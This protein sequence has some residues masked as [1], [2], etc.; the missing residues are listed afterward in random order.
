MTLLSSEVCF[1]YPRGH[2]L[3]K[4]F[5]A[6]PDG[7]PGFGLVILRFAVAVNAIS[8]GICIL[9]AWR[10]LVLTVS[11][12]GLLAIVVG[13]VFLAGFL[14]P[15]AGSILA[16]SYLIDAVS[17]FLS[18]GEYSHAIAFTALYLASISL[19][20]ALLGPG[21]YSVDARLFGRLEIIIPD[22]RRPPQ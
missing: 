2:R 15:I 7:W 17:L 13:L 10:G 9:T 3:R 4:F 22:R 1:R 19:A 11:A 12:L 5:S 14:T 6:F 21:A 20:L 8:Q 18:S 16:I